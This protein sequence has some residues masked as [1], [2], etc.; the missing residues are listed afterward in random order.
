M[1]KSKAR[2]NCIYQKGIIIIKDTNF[3]EA[4]FRIIIY[5]DNQCHEA[6]QDKR[7]KKH[8]FSSNACNF[9]DKHNI[10]ISG[11]FKSLYDLIL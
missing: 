2:N 11:A 6:I 10:K 9:I 4:K 1:G 7:H 8:I 5:D 3:N